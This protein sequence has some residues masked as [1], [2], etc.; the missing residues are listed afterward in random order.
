MLV[1]DYK[2]CYNIVIPKERQ[3]KNLEESKNST[4]FAL[5]EPFL[6]RSISQ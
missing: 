2:P 6:H 4:E 5:A 1:S 3:V